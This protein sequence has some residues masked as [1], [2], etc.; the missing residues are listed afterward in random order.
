MNAEDFAFNL[1][2]PLLPRLHEKAKIDLVMYVLSL[3]DIKFNFVQCMELVNKPLDDLDDKLLFDSAQWSSLI[4][5]LSDN[6]EPN[7]Y[8]SN[9][10]EISEL[11]AIGAI[12][13]QSLAKQV[14][15][16]LNQHNIL[17]ADPALDLLKLNA[18][19][20]TT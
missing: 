6:V 9:P 11:M 20:G 3:T 8:I 12:V 7:C 4:K 2:V 1:L 15:H 16:K 13:P 5:S 19:L 14:L 17:T 10:F 18:E